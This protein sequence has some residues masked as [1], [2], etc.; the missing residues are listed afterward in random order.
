[1][2]TGE[3]KG[4]IKEG[5]GGFRYGRGSIFHSNCGGERLG[6][7]EGSQVKMQVG[8]TFRDHPG[9]SRGRRVGV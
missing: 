9:G 5:G 3:T 1:M 8:R 2:E 6:G 4:S 7:V